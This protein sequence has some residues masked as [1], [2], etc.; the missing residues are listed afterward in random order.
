[1]NDLGLLTLRGATG[2]LLAGHGAQK[3]F[4]WYGGHG[5]EGT[6]DWLESMGMR[7]GKRWAMAAGTSEFGGGVLTALG[8]GGGVGPAMTLGAMEMATRMAHWGKPIWVTSGG[9]ELPVTNMAVAI[10]LALSGPGK[11][12]LDSALGIKTPTWMTGV[13]LGATLAGVVYGLSLHHQ[14]QEQIHGA[15]GADEAAAVGQPDQREDDFKLP[16]AEQ[17]PLT[18]AAVGAV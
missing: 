5:L 18:T 1:L 6:S 10:A 12:S 11:Y 2:A 15:T 8:L 14:A 13:A 3:L 9:A 17:E 7:P 4:G 16:A